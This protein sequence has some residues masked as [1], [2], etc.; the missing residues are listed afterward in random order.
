MVERGL[1]RSRR[2]LE[3]TGADAGVVDAVAGRLS[4]FD[5]YLR[6]VAPVAFL[7]DTTT[8]NVIV[9]EGR[10]SGI[11]DT[12]YVCFGDPLYALGLTRMALLSDGF[13]TTYTDAWAAALGLDEAAS[14]AV[15]LYTA[16]FCVDFMSELGQRFNRD[17]ASAIEPARVRLLRRILDE[18]LE[19]LP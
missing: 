4:A 6:G 12:D 16:L 18:Q 9:H 1:A 13:D 8:K 5:G 3:S 2:R 14:A 11:V 15:V 19:A 10:L 17:E 7:D